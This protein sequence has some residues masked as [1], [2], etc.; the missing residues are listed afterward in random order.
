MDSKKLIHNILSLGSSEILARLIAFVGTAYI[1][2]LL[3]PTGFGI[4]GFALAVV[5]YLSIGVAQGFEQVGVREIVRQ[6]RGALAMA[7]NVAA[8]KVAL[9]FGGWVLLGM[10][11]FFLNKPLDVK[12]VMMLTGLSLFT[13]ALDTSWVFK[14]LERNH[15]VGVALVLG[16]LAYVGAVLLMVRDA[17]D[18]LFVPVSR[19][20][21][22][23][24]AAILLAFSL[25]RLG[26]ARKGV[27]FDF[28]Q[29]LSLM[30]SSRFVMFTRL[31][32]TLIFTF[33][34]LFLGFFLGERAVGLYAASYRFCFLL[35]AIAASIQI[36]YL[37]AFT[38]AANRGSEQVA[39]TA[40]RS[41]EVSSALSLPMVVGGVLLA[42]PLLTALY[43]AEYL[44]GKAAL[45]LLIVSIGQ[46][47]LYGM[48]HNVLVVYDRLK[49]EMWVMAVG[50][51]INIILNIILIP[52]YG[53]VGAAFATV[54]A[55]GA[56]LLLG[57]SLV[58]KELRVGRVVSAMFRPI[59]A[60][61]VMGI[62][63]A[64]LD[65]NLAASLVMG[66]FVYITAL[67]AMG[68]IPQDIRSYWQTSGV[69]L[70]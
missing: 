18:I 29:G 39:E 59:L 56:I 64:S 43:G 16:Q 65:F 28:R 25:F 17:H 1:A 70:E 4:V 42:G 7:V 22:E 49:V 3:G 48:I 53:L 10:I 69:V 24:A 33:D 38:R 50:A 58:W 66:V 47:F 15:V 45:Q 23:L 60:A 19:F 36:S 20:L 40:R 8:V 31:S 67:A 37:P 41:L 55:E 21:G 44:E 14:G 26:K 57:L 62:S 51:V 13:L 27:F 52:L 68:G 46:I 54:L 30:R 61:V 34:V 9:A 32:K 6:P 5:G 2:R 63:L 11:A 12:L 35:L